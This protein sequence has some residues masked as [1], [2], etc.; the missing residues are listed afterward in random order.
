MKSEWHY[1][2]FAVILTLLWRCK[3][4]CLTWKRKL[5]NKYFCIFDLLLSFLYLMFPPFFTNF[6]NSSLNRPRNTTYRV[7]FSKTRCYFFVIF[8]Q[9]LKYVYEIKQSKVIE[10]VNIWAQLKNCLVAQKDIVGEL[11]FQFIFFCILQQ[12]KLSTSCWRVI[13]YHCSFCWTNYS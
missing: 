1:Q 5:V 11:Y 8:I 12:N 6:Y 9:I 3:K 2:E 7:H 13:W 10:T 4:G